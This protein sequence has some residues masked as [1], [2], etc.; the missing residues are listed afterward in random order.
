MTD[1]YLLYI[2]ILGFSNIVS[3]DKSR[4]NDLYEVI[5]S[6]NVHNHEAFK[7]VV[8]SDTILVYNLVSAISEHDRKY[9]VMYLCEFAQDLMRRLV[10]RNIVFRAVLIKGDFT[11]YELNSIPCFY[12]TALIEAYKNEKDINAIGLFISKELDKDNDIFKSRS[13]NNNFNFV[14]ITQALQRVERDFQGNFPIEAW[15]FEETD[16]IWYIVPEVLIMEHIYLN[17]N[18]KLTQSIKQKYQTTWS[19]YESEYPN[20]LKFLVKNRFDVFKM[21]PNA[22]WEEVL[23]RYPEK[24]NWAVKT[25]NEF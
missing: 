21:S 25:R 5:A 3:T 15:C 9:L 4:I 7:T 8:F 20:T 6:L 24:Y 10:K 16:E 11:H 1:R 23:E 17:A 2:D 19:F 22:K 13:F 12:G 18:A 14:Y